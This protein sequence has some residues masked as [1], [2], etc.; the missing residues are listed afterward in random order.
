MLGVSVMKLP[1]LLGYFSIAS[2]VLAFLLFGSTSSYS[3]LVQNPEFEKS[4]LGKSS[5]LFM[6]LGILVPWA[7]AMYKT[8]NKNQK[9]FWLCFLFWPIT[10]YYLLILSG[11]SEKVTH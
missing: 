5:L 10:S 8:Y 4:L 2:V 6:M 9:W 11:K 1:R 7:Y 3:G